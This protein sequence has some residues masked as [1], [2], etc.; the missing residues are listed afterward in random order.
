MLT[1]DGVWGAEVGVSPSSNLPAAGRRRSLPGRV[2]LACQVMAAPSRLQQFLR[3]D[4]YSLS[5]DKRTGALV[6]LV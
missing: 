2:G 3:D 6:E 4:L 5:C 1:I